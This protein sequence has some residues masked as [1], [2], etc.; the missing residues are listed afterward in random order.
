MSWK[1][2]TCDNSDKP[3]SFFDVFLFFFVNSFNC[4]EVL[5]YV[6]RQQELITPLLQHPG[7]SF[8]GIKCVLNNSLPHLEDQNYYNMFSL[9]YIFKLPLFGT[10]TAALILTRGADEDMCVNVWHS[11]FLI[12]PSVT[13]F[14]GH[15]KSCYKYCTLMLMILI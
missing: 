12:C 8:R 11:H 4:L 13:C 9:E 3:Y 6:S 7:V 5:N 14:H 2:S 10:I 15:L 1:V